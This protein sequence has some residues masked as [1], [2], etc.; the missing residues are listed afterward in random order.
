MSLILEDDNKSYIKTQTGFG[1]VKWMSPE[2]IINKRYSKYCLIILKKNNS[3]FP[4]GT[5]SD[6]WSFGKIYCYKKT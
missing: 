2:T 3:Y 6:I 5:K 1:P 4:S